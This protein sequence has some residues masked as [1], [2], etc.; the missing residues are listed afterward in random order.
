MR[1]DI[2]PIH[3]NNSIFNQSQSPF[4]AHNTSQMNMSARMQD[5]NKSSLPAA[6]QSLGSIN[7]VTS[8][9]ANEKPEVENIDLPNKQKEVN[10]T[11]VPAQF[12]N[13]LNRK[14]NKNDFYRFL[15][16]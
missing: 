15:L 6:T 4:Q 10:I 1:S 16:Q 7:I 3:L 2:K 12:P 8:K 13:N 9:N 5:T 11:T 14:K